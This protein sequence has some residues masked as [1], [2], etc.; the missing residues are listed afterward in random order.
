MPPTPRLILFPGLGADERMFAAQR[1]VFPQLEVPPRLDAVA[2]ES[3]ADHARRLA[4]RLDV[5]RPFM[6]GGVSIGGMIAQELARLT[7]PRMLILIATA[8]AGRQIPR[9]FRFYEMLSRP[10]PERVLRT[11]RFI[12]P[13]ISRRFSGVTPE[14]ER[15]VTQMVNDTP[16]SYIRWGAQAIFGWPGCPPPECPLRHIHGA[17]DRLI[18]PRGMSPDR[19]IE[20]GGHLINMTHAE[21]VN[22][23][24]AEALGQAADERGQ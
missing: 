5:R 14:Q 2:G 10:L 22:A 8:R 12:Q 7:S 18:P 24:I 23:F 1:A 11:G 6:L 20:G 17:G 3:I 4:Q 16:L 19:L 9:H 15:L 21:E 13:L